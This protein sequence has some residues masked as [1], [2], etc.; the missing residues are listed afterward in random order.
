MFM[1]TSM[2]SKSCDNCE[3]NNNGWCWLRNEDI[4]GPG[5]CVYFTEK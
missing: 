2:S 4:F 5:Y 3:Y 1:I